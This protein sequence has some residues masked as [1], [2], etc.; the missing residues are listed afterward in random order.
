MKKYR[1][2]TF[3][4]LLGMCIGCAN[5]G[6][7]EGG[8]KDETPPKVTHTYPKNYSVNF[9][10]DRIV[11][12]FDEFVKLNDANKNVIISPPQKKKPKVRLKEKKIVID[13]LDSLR[14][15]TTYV[16][17]FG[18]AIVDNNEGNQ[19]GEYRYV[20]STGKEIAKMGLAGYVK[21]AKVDTA[22]TVAKVG[23]Y[24]ASDTLNPYRILPE[25]IAQ[26]DS[27]GFFMFNNIEDRAY[28]IIAFI[29]NNSNNMLDSDEPLAFQKKNVDTSIPQNTEEDSLQFDKYTKFK[30]TNLQLRIFKPIPKQQFLKDFKRSL[31]E[32]FVFVFNAPRKDSLKI[33][34]LDTT[35]D[36]KFFIESN[37]SQ[38]SLVYWIMNNTISKKDTLFAKL[39]YL[40]TDTLGNLVPYIDTL[41][42]TYKEP[43]KDKKRK[44]DK[45]KKEEEPKIKMMKIQTNMTGE[46]NYFDTLNLSFEYPILELKKEDVVISTKKDTID[47]P[48]KFTLKK[49]N[50]RRYNI[51]MPLQAGSE[52]YTIKIDSMK[53]FDI[54]GRANE[55][56]TSSFSTHEEAFYGKLF[57]TVT[58]GDATVLIQL[59]NKTTPNK[60]VAEQKYKEGQVIKFENL[61]PATYILKA[62]WDTNSNGKWDTGDYE[63][64]LQP[65]RMK[66]FKKEIEL[67]SNWEQEVAWRLKGS[68][69]KVKPIMPKEVKELK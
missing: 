31:R 9:D 64:Q 23:L 34:L 24:S 68:E 25:Y 47:V 19:M 13:L 36:P 44:K 69:I 4:A 29:D 45:D 43:K 7:P 14:A 62:L 42:L 6:V 46:I 3:I 28:K 8:A 1:K 53:V 56:F 17:D 26:T 57:V 48:Q 55:N 60:V 11:I 32:Q 40:Q 63:K 21:G 61:P 38:D 2:I 33:E 51:L 59:A 30:N 39:S 50:L 37:P 15:N 16:L 18:K 22:S 10:K 49:E 35:E 66:I 41:K 67:R 65:E 52:K 27:L 58:G 12:D 20:F 5:P 54:A